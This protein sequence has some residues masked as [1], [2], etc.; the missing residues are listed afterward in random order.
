MTAFPIT[1]PAFKA[2]IDAVSERGTLAFTPRQLYYQVLRQQRRRSPARAGRA[3]GGLCLFWA[4]GAALF[5][6]L[7]PA[8]RVL[9]IGLALLVAAGVVLVGYAIR[10][11]VASR[12]TALPGPAPTAA[13]GFDQFRGT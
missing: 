1:D 4:L 12:A 9:P 13:I 8:T 2:A 7:G 5:L 6:G 11:L 3:A 10:G